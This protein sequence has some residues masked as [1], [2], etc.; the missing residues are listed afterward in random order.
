MTYGFIKNVILCEG[1][2]KLST[3]AL[4]YSK[5]DLAPAVSKATLDY[6]YEELAK[7]Y[8]RRYNAGEGDADFNEAGSFLHNILFAQ[9][10]K[11]SDTNQPNGPILEF[12]EKHFGSFAKF[13]DAFAKTAMGIQGSG[14]VY[15]SQSGK[16]HTIKNHAIKSDIVLLVDWW[17][18]AWALDYQSDKKEYLNN[19]WH[20]INWDHISAA[21]R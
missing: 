13:K 9:Y 10:Q 4:S 2:Q 17:E 8:A 7:G 14:W 1:K 6:H 3:L 18:H 11:Y 12:M 20:I 15:L 21:L 16:I 19:Q 5:R